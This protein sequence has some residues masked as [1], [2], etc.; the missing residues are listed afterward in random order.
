[1]LF[2]ELADASRQLA[3]TTKR[4]AKAAVLA[5]LLRRMAPDEVEA[6]VGVLTG[7]LR[8]GRIGVG[9][10]TLRD[11]RP[12]PA[13]VPTLTVL[14]VDASVERLAAMSGAGVNAARR[15]LLHDVFARATE[16]EQ[17]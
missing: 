9:W 12:E 8:Q 10:A 4:G 2:V 11:V 15:E 7:A 16:P 17:D 3:A 14:E 1:M 6:G 13:T 5:D